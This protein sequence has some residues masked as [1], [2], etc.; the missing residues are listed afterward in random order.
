MSLKYF[1]E[2]L[3][4]TKDFTKSNLE[5]GEYE[6]CT[7][8]G[9]DISNTDLSNFVFSECTFLNCNL[10]NCKVKETAFREVEFTDCKL[11]GLHFEDCKAFLFSI[12]VVNCNLNLSCFF[13]VNLKRSKIK[14]SSLHEVDFTSA[15]LSNLHLDNWDLLNATFMGTNLEAADL[16]LAIN[17]SIDPE[18]NKIKK[19]KFSSTGIAGLLHRYDIVIE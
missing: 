1:D 2:Q 15:D 13:Q 6:R 14:N 18:L 10:S 16:R 5:I 8:K 19:A 9:L 17:Y 4:E 11:L 12:Y 3:F 7:F